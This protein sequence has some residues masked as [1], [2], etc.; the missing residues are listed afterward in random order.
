MCVYLISTLQRIHRT[1]VCSMLD[2]ENRTCE[3]LPVRVELEDSHIVTHCK[4]GFSESG[5]IT[6]FLKAGRHSHMPM[7]DETVVYVQFSPSRKDLM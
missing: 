5:S 3:T 1:Q 2:K 7:L 6:A 4:C